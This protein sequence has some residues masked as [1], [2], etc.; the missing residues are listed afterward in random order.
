M[1]IALKIVHSDFVPFS[2]GLNND[3]AILKFRG[4][5]TLNDFVRP[6]CLPSSTSFEQFDDI[7]LIVAGFGRTETSDNSRVKLKTEVRGITNNACKEF[8]VNEQQKITENQICALGE[9]GK[10]S[11]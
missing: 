5:A 7:P 3:I 2:S 6:I 4:T 1:P 8:Y 10:D 11:W 9:D